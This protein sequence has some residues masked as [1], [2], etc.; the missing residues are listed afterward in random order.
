MQQRQRQL[1]DAHVVVLPVRAGRAK[2]PRVAFA[3][4]GGLTLKLHRSIAIDLIGNAETLAFPFAGLLQQLRPCDAAVVLAVEADAGPAHT[5]AHPPRAA[6]RGRM[7]FPQAGP[8][9][10][11]PR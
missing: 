4:L 6:A 1:V 9:R 10:S 2:R 11:S 5:P 8:G 7:L 3:A